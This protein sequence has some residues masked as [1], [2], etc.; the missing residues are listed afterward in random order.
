ME[1]YK[2]YNYSKEGETYTVYN[3]EGEAWIEGFKTEEEAK[4]QIDDLVIQEENAQEEKTQ[5]EQMQEEITNLQ[6]AMLEVLEG[7]K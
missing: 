7:G 3:K 5:M 4:A 6:L 1:E 2:G